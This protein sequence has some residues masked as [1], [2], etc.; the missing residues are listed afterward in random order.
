MSLEEVFSIEKL[1][2][3]DG[4]RAMSVA[5]LLIDSDV[6]SV[7]GLGCIRKVAE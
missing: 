2:P 5:Y 3:P 7:R 4:S 1:P 6:G